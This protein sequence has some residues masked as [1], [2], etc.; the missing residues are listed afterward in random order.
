MG[1]YDRDYY[2][3]TWQS[4]GRARQEHSAIFYVILLNVIIWL[5]DAFTNGQMCQRFALRAVDFP[6]PL[7]WYRFLTY[8]FCHSAGVWHILGN[9]LG[10]FFLG[11]YVER[12]YGKW[13]FLF[14]YLVSIFIGGLYW[15][16]TSYV[17]LLQARETVSAAEIFMRANIP[18]VGA[19]GGVVAVV[20]LFSLNFPR[21]MLYIYGIIPVP[22]FVLGILYV[23]L[24]LTGVGP[25]NVAHSVH[26]AGAAFALLYYLAGMRIT[27]LFGSCTPRLHPYSAGNSAPYDTGD[28]SRGGSYQEDDSEYEDDSYGYAPASRTPEEVRSEEEFRKLQE[29]VEGLLKKISESGMQSLTPSELARLREASKKYRSRG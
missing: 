22:A 23:V 26:L 16:G 24:D 6:Q 14:F 13:E 1:I 8:G 2:R 9:M 17:T 19:S 28:R 3:E 25:E 11:Q 21:V 15:A 4:P 29:D 20:I 7:H 18:L 5:L 27:S 12:K 10:L